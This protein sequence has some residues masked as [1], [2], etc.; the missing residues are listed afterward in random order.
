MQKLLIFIVFLPL[1]VFAQE[2]PPVLNYSPNDYEAGNQNWMISQGENHQVYVANN[3]GLLHFDGEHWILYK[4]PGGTAVRSVLASEENI[5]TGSYMDFGFW[6]ANEN[7]RLR[8]FSLKDSVSSGLIDGEQFWDIKEVDDHVIFQSHQRLYSFNKKSG[9][10]TSVITETNISNLFK[11]RNKIY[12]QIADKGLFIVQDGIGRPFISEEKIENKYIIG[13]FP[14]SDD[15]I[16]AVTRDDGVYIITGNQWEEFSINDYPLSTSFFSA[17]YLKDGTL[18]LGSIGSGLY[19]IDLNGNRLFHLLQ[20]TVL[21]NT[22]LSVMEDQEGNLWGGLDNGIAV[23]NKESPFRLFVDI[24]G[25]IGTVYCSSVVNDIFYLGTNQGLYFKKFGSDEAF[26]LIPGTTGQVWSINNINGNVY[27]GH[28]RGTFRINGNSTSHIWDGLGTWTVRSIGSGILQG[29]YNGLSFLPDSVSQGTPRYLENFD[30]SA[31]NILVE[32]DSVVWVGHYHKG[33]LRLKLNKDYTRVVELENYDKID[34][35]GLGPEVFMYNQEIYYSTEDSVY[36]YDKKKN[37]F[38]PDNELNKLTR[39]NDRIS[40]NSYSLNDGT[41]WTFSKDYLYY[42]AR[43]PF[44]QK[45]IGH[46][47]PLPI[48]N[49]NITNGFENI[50]ILEKNRYLVGSNLG[51]IEFTLPLEKIPSGDLSINAVGT[52]V[53]GEKYTYRELNAK[54][55]ELENDMNSIL[56]LFSIPNYQSLTKTEYSYRLLNFSSSWSKWDYTGIAAFENLPSGNY[57]FEVKGRINDHETETLSYNFS[58]SKP[59]YY[60][61]VAI[62]SYILLFFLGLLVI[63]Y[64]YKRHHKKIIQEKEK[65]LR[66]QTLEAEQQIIKLQKEHLERDMEEKNGQLAASTMSL[67]KKNEFL[68]N[69]KKELKNTEISKVKGVIKTIDKE[70]KEEDNWKMFREAFKNV[71]KDFFEKIKAKHPE[72]TSNDLRLCAYL[73]LNLSSKEIAPLINISLKSVEIKRYRLRKKMNLPREVNL[74]DYIIDI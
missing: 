42:V 69:L 44:E 51:Y 68:S 11:I 65:N 36:L 66:M 70:I 24:F 22:F 48:E 73:R 8:Y 26:S 6:Q 54:K 71:D 64:V 49:R 63:H 17:S 4:V 61:N 55:L 3:S 62:A 20:P 15:K 39:K 18:A 45:L 67:I 59:W 30:L 23:I 27:A 37:I 47:I 40:G 2:L 25:E 7:G 50:S 72:L 53:K 13:L 33:V 60:S 58:I 1:A 35:P 41:W 57:T 21:N 19:V 56:F 32:N 52:S 10:V 16:L 38:T 5:Y 12:Y 34:L 46:K 14:Y 29:H 31:R 28:D 9:K 74:T 43:D